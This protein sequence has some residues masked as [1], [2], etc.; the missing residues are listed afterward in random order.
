MKVRGESHQTSRL[1]KWDR[2]ND[3]GAAGGGAPEK[4][5]KMRFM[6]EFPQH[7]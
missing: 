5:G 3:P 2:G 6:T 7:F 4:M 1:T